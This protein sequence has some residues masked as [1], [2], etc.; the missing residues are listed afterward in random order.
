VEG[1]S[2]HL[3]TGSGFAQQEHRQTGTRSFVDHAPDS[4]DCRRLPHEPG[5]ADRTITIHRLSVRI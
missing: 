3:L 2:H 4:T 1:A 5:G